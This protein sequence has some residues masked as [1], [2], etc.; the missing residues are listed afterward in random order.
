MTRI[1]KGHNI[2]GESSRAG[3]AAAEDPNLA[4]G[5]PAAREE[6]LS[7]EWDDLMEAIR[8]TSRSTK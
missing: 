4:L 6:P 2:P 3:T 1:Y 5:L 7:V 8:E